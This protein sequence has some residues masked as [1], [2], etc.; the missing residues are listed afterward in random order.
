MRKIIYRRFSGSFYTS[1]S[2]DWKPA[3]EKKLFLDSQRRKLKELVTG[4]RPNR[5]KKYHVRVRF[6]FLPKR[7]GSD[8]DNLLKAF[9]DIV[10]GKNRDQR[11]YSI[12]AMK[13]PDQNEGIRFWIYELE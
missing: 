6:H 7:M 1:G 2:Q 11:I 13:I 10:F 9:N 8:L 3:T 4:F 5:A 12:S